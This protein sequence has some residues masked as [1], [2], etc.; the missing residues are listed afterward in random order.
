MRD[1]NIQP[2]ATLHLALRIRGGGPTGLYIPGNFLDPKYNRDFT[3]VNDNHRDF[4]RGGEEYKRPCGWMRFALKVEDKFDSNVWLGYTNAVGEW[5][6]S[7]HGTSEHNASS[8]ADEGYKLAKGRNFNYGYGIYSTPSIRTAEQF[9]KAFWVG[10]RRYKVI[11]QNR[12]NP[13]CLTKEK[14]PKK[15][16]WISARDEDIRAYGLCIK[17]I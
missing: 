6:V 11:L 17:Q 7:Y 16:Y 2:N 13:A 8:I 9:G 10:K 3:Y 12:V 4:Y 14:G 1:Y 5:P 15:D